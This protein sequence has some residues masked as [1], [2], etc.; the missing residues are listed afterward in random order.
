MHPCGL[1]KSRR[2]F[3]ESWILKEGGEVVTMAEEGVVAL[4]EDKLLEGPTL[5]TA[6]AKI[7]SKVIQYMS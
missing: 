4:V 2:K 7:D 5:E 1:S 3:F 6:I